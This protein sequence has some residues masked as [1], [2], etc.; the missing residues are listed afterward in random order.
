MLYC[1]VFPGS[2]LRC[3]ER[4]FLKMTGDESL[5]LL[6][7]GFPRAELKPDDEVVV[8]ISYRELLNFFTKLANHYRFIDRVK[9]ID[10]GTG[11]SSFSSEAAFHEDMSHEVGPIGLG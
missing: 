1:E 3:G 11:R 8:V 6:S 10:D 9:R 4:L 5:F 2:V 7:S